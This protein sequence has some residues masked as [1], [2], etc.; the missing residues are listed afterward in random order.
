MEYYLGYRKSIE[1][2]CML[3]YDWSFEDLFSLIV[4]S[5]I[6][7]SVDS[8]VKTLSM[9]AG[10]DTVL[11]ESYYDRDLPKDPGDNIF[12]EN[13]EFVERIKQ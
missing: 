4:N 6:V 7:Y 12:I 11:I 3:I 1:E 5:K 10:V 9:L 2:R 8:W 13:W